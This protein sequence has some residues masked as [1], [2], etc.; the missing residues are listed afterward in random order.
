M[1]KTIDD[2]NVG[3]AEQPGLLWYRFLNKWREKLEAVVLRAQRHA[4]TATLV[5]LC[6]HT[7]NTIDG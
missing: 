2:Y 6:A 5:L 4:A 3:D 1:T 7:I